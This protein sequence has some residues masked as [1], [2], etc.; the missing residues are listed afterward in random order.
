MTLPFARATIK[1]ERET[2][3]QIAYS[4]ALAIPRSYSFDRCIDAGSTIGKQVQ[5]GNN[6]DSEHLYPDLSNDP[7]QCALKLWVRKIGTRSLAD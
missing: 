7:Y 2:A 5:R 6:Y 3:F 1:P 4:I